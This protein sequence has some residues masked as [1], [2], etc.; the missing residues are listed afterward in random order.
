MPF[1]FAAPIGSMVASTVASKLKVPP[2]YLVLCSSTLQ[3]IGFA[4]LATLTESSTI[5]ARM[6]GFQV[7]A[8]F[9]CGINIST[10]VLMVPFCVEFRD[11]GKCDNI[12]LEI[13][14][15]RLLQRWE[16]ALYHSFA[17]WEVQ[18]Y[19]QLQRLFSIALLGPG[20]PQ[21]LAHWV[22]I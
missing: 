14:D 12:E 3:V 11:K 20:S 13:Q 19:S 10:L 17:Q 2:I 22:R 18:L 7:I 6:Y 5:P 8:G 4:L 15:S 9:G 21:Y 16:W 1:T